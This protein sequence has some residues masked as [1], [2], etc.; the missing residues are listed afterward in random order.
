MGL[1][2]G[3]IEIDGININ[4]ITLNDLR[5]K[6]SIIPQDSIL[7]TGTLRHNLDPFRTRNDDEIWDAL[8]QVELKQMVSKMTDGINTKISDDGANFS[9][10][11]RQLICLARAILRR[12]KILILDEAT[13]N[14]DPK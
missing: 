6:I 8:E 9:M 14:V 13:A 10:G 3:I 4:N 7:F 2:D 11:Q 5:R 1:N 12:N